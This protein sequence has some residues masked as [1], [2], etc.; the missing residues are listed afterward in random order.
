MTAFDKI[1][2]YLEKVTPERPPVLREM[3]QYAKEQNFPIVGPLVGRLLYQL[4]IA[5]KAKRVFELGSG[6]GYSAFWLSMAAQGKGR[7][8]MTDWDRRNKRLAFDYFKRAGLT[9]HFEFRVGDGLRVLKRTEG[10][11]DLILNDIDKEAYPQTIDTV[12]T[13][14]R[15]GGLFITDNVIWSGKVCDTKPDGTSRAIIEFNKRLYEDG[16]FFTTIVPLRDGLS[17]ATRL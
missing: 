13:K 9:S 2:R 4:A 1:H 12:A 10:P 17:L 5:T 15:K 11:F 3:E 6:F 14:L 8:T 16:R 7:I